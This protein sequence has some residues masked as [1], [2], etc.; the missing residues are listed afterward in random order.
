VVNIH[1]ENGD[2]EAGQCH[3]FDD[4]KH[5][6]FIQELIKDHRQFGLRL[7]VTDS[8]TGDKIFEELYYSGESASFAS[9]DNQWV[10]Y[11]FENEPMVIFGFQWHSFGCPFITFI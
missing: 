5:H 8:K 11:L 1:F 10:G 6:F 2:Y 4:E 9:L 3:V 7:L